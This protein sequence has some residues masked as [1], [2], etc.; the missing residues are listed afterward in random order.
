MQPL[1]VV[2]IEHQ[3][4]KPILV[5]MLHSNQE[6]DQKPQRRKPPKEKTLDRCDFPES[7]SLR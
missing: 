4:A 1:G 2:T 5:N 7:L 3:L 6:E